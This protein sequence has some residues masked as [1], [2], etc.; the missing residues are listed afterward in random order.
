MNAP[1]VTGPAAFNLG[2]PEPFIW[3]SAVSGWKFT[4]TG[5]GDPSF[6]GEYVAED[7]ATG[8]Y[9]H[10]EQTDRFL[11]FLSDYGSQY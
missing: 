1:I 7:E 5:A 11:N 6:D 8:L 3:K 10:V 2:H 9:R 4:A